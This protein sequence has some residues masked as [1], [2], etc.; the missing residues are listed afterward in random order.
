MGGGHSQPVINDITMDWYDQTK[1][2]NHTNHDNIT[3]IQRFQNNISACWKFNEFFYEFAVVMETKEKKYEYEKRNGWINQKNTDTKEIITAV[4]LFCPVPPWFDVKLG[5]EYKEY[6][7]DGLMQD[8]NPDVG[9]VGCME[10]PCSGEDELNYRFVVV[11][12]GPEQPSCTRQTSE[13]ENHNFGCVHYGEKQKCNPIIDHAIKVILLDDRPITI[14]DTLL[15]PVYEF[16]SCQ[17]ITGDEENVGFT[18]EKI[19][20]KD[21]PLPRLHFCFSYSNFYPIYLLWMEKVC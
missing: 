12:K 6:K 15:Y 4:R 13:Y 18:F 11:W 7:N 21:N 8:F 20:T 9:C 16:P 19:K 5:H 17:S 10:E 3:T 14:H 1:K 2:S